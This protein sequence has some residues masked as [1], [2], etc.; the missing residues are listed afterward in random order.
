MYKKIYKSMRRLAVIMAILVAV[1][2]YFVACGI[3][4]ECKQDAVDAQAQILADVLNADS[5]FAVEKAME[6]GHYLV[7]ILSADEALVYSNKNY[8]GLP[9][10]K[11][12]TY[13]EVL[14]NGYVLRVSCAKHEL[15]ADALWLLL[16]F[17]VIILL[18]Y[19]AAIAISLRLSDKIV[20]PIEHIDAVDIQYD[21]VYPELVPLLRSIS[22]QRREIQ[23]LSDRVERQNLRFRAIGEQMTDGIVLLGR[24]RKI[25]MVN[26]AALSAFGALETEVLGQNFIQL[27]RDAELCNSLE[28]AWEGHRYQTE[29]MLDGKPY[30]IYCS[31]I[32][33]E[34]IVTGVLLMLFDIRERREAELMRREFSANVS[35]ELKSPLT[36]VLG[37]AQL[38]HSGMAKAEDVPVFAGKIEKEATRLLNLIDDIIELSKLDEMQEPP[39]KTELSLEG[40]I[41]EVIDLLAD[42]AAARGIEIAYT[43]E[44]TLIEGNLRQ[45]SELVYNLCDN[46][47]K[48]NKE[49]GSVKIT[50]SEK[51][52]CIEDTGIGIAPQYTERIFERF[53]RVDKSRSRGAG[54]TGL[55]LSIVKHIAQAHGAQ[56]SVNSK[57]GE[58][59][60]FMVKF[61]K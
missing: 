21:K 25:N 61:G 40:V 9:E 16:P 7:R 18:A 39:Q 35:H 5:D 45:I 33:Q 43:G 14:E 11:L 24:S 41:I 23:R 22:A 19:I 34:G 1:I 2:T 46:A 20:D 13:E 59:T 31:P 54:G 49:N 29:R 56:I 52:L 42:K 28:K 50:L 60:S 37:Y 55:G 26:A 36:S 53:F 4:V 3:L 58:G 30:Q 10:N 17:V 27:C 8:A 48:Y 47:I 12:Y 38:M 6:D 57:P 51:T 44:D 32:L 15:Y